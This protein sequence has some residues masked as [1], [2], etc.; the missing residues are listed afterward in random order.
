MKTKNQIVLNAEKMFKRKGGQNYRLR[1][2]YYG[3]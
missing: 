2:A 1:N 3:N